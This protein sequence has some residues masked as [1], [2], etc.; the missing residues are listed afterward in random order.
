MRSWG[1]LPVN[2]GYRFEGGLPVMM[3]TNLTKLRSLRADVEP[4]FS[5]WQIDGW[6]GIANGAHGFSPEN[7]QNFRKNLRIKMTKNTR[8]L[9]NKT[10]F[11]SELL[12]VQMR[13]H[14]AR[15][16]IGS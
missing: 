6:R 5:G 7:D 12:K 4:P 8:F 13:L 10:V 3:M 11:F 2:T 1:G 15:F 16:F 14:P 9:R